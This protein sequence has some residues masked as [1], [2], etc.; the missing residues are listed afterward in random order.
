MKKP[1]L[2]GL[3]VALLTLVT[4]A[5]IAAAP[6]PASAHA[7]AASSVRATGLTLVPA[8]TTGYYLMR[9]ADGGGAYCLDAN[10]GNTGGLYAGDNVQ[11]WTCN[12]RSNQYWRFNGTELQ[13]ADTAQGTFCLD[14]YAGAIGSGDYLQLWGC[15]GRSNQQWYV[16]TN[17]GSP[18]GYY[19]LENGANTSLCLDAY[20]GA[21]GSGDN[22]QL[23][24]CNNHSN[25]GWTVP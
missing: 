23:W 9:N 24:S 21:I 5:G 11:L 18:N 8:A 10:T 2:R 1:H 7:A 15:N 16:T 17:T 14:A 19:G 22:I 6:A 4:A 20:A 13:N 25:Q 12:G 3:A